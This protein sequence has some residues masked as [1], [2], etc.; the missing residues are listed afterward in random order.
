MPAKAG[1]QLL[2]LM[3]NISGF[4]S[5]KEG[6]LDTRLRGLTQQWLG[7]STSKRTPFRRENIWTAMWQ[8]L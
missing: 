3:G 5:T 4:V 6:K 8:P 7:V 1:I 2:I